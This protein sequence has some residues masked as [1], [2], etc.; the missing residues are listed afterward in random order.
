MKDKNELQKKIEVILNFEESGRTADLTRCLGLEIVHCNEKG[1][2]VRALKEFEKG[3]PICEYRGTLIQ[4]LKAIQ[5]VENNYNAQDVGSY[6]YYFT[7][8][9][10]QYMIDATKEDS[11]IARFINH[12]KRDANVKGSIIEYSGKPRLLFFAI[13]NIKPGVEIA[14]DYMDQNKES[15]K[16]FPWLLN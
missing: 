4:G 10:A 7:I 2:G 15:T 1:K 11:G 8:A 6:L 14:Y 3:D 16:S 12:S 5:A 13:T 9:D